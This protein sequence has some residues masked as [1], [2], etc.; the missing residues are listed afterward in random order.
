[1]QLNEIYQQQIA[2]CDEEIEAY[3]TGLDS[4]IKLEEIEST[5]KP[6]PKKKK[7]GG[8][9]PGFDLKSHLYR[10]SGVDFTRIDGLG[11]KI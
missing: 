1:M 3:L 4:Q 9:E 11:V 6:P 2:Q 8:N 5:K 7:C 10:I